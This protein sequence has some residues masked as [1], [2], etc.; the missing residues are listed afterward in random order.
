MTDWT[1]ALRY[2]WQGEGWF[3]R[4]LPLALLQLAPLVGQVILVGYGQAVVRATYRQ[5]RDLPRLHLRRSLVDGLRLTSVGVVYCLPAILMVLLVF[6]TS[7]TP[8][9]QT[10]GGVPAIV[11]PAIM[12]VYLRISSE[13]VKR[14]PALQSI[15]S[16]INRIVSALFV[17]YIIMRLYALFVTLR[18][19]VQFSTIQ[20]DGPVLMTLLIASLLFAIIIVALLVS[21]VRFTITGTGLLK[22]HTTLQLMAANLNLTARFMVTVWLLVAGIV[23]AAAIGMVFLLVPGLLLIV[24]GNIS[25]WFL[26][27]QYATQIGIRSSS[28]CAFV[29]SVGN[30]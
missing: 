3:W 29:Q 28:N 15:F 17:M 20:L 11:Y 16:L 2:P 9:T 23:I 4:M 27:T 18:K 12:L 26:T 8:A 13:I 19:G 24:A 10:S 21:G 5:Q 30:S 6:S 25:I 7:D 14:R 22:P 1:R